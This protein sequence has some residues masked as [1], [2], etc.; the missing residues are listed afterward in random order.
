MKQTGFFISFLLAA[1]LVFINSAQAFQKNNSA[2]P[3][4]KIGLVLSGGGAKGMAHVG[5]IRA[6][7]KAGIRPDYV[8]GTSMGS[9]VG[10]LYAMGYN[11]EELEKIIRS[12]DWDLI[13]SNR[14]GFETIAFEEKEYYNRYLV[15]LPV[16][17]GKI[18]LPS[19][20]IEGQM[21]SEVLQYYTW[22]ARK[23]ANFDEFPI[24]F[25][26]IATDIGTGK[27]IVF[28]RG[29][30]HDALRSSIAIPTAF[31]AFQLDST[32]VVDGGVVNNF[33]VD[34]A[35]GLGA[36]IV[37]GVNVSDE[38]FIEAEKLEG[39]GAILMQLA[40]AQSLGKTSENI[41]LTD[42]YIK[43][44]LGPYGTASFGD[45]DAILKI[46]DKTGEIFYPRFKELA[47]S[48]GLNSVPNGIGLEAR[49]VRFSSIKVEGNRIFPTSLILS[50]LGI[51]QGQEVSREELQDGINRVFGINGFYKVDYKLVPTGSDEYELDIRVKEKSSHL[52]STSVHYDNQFSAGILLNYT[53]RDFIGK[54]SRTVLLADISQN[55]K[56]RFDYYKYIG[57]EKRFAFNLKANY[58]NQ[59]QP[60]YENG[61]TTGLQK[62]RNSKLEAQLIST[63]S[64]KQAFYLGMYF[65]NENSKYL[66]NDLA[67]EELKS[68]YQRFIGL[69]FRYYRNSQNDRNFPTHGAE[70]LIETNFN[71]KDWLGINTVAGADS[72]SIKL[73]EDFFRVSIEDFSDLVQLF[74]PNP[75]GTING[76]YSKY[77]SLSPKLQFHP[78]TAFGVIL[79]DESSSK[80]YREFFVGGYQNI[81]FGDTPFWGLN[82]AE[83]QT[84]NFLKVGAEFQLEPISKI[85]LRA[86]ANWLGYSQQYPIG[87]PD[88]TGKIFQDESYLGYGADV[89]Y[90][91]ILGPIS[92]GISSNSRDKQVRTYFSIGLSLNYSDR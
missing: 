76:R 66:L 50:K 35:K 33:P 21:L 10:G 73:G 29:Y 62:F 86:G 53:M 58:L 92:F 91:S 18:S 16:R 85:Y 52:L 88:W 3:K 4:P 40:M 49:P 54:F 25:R 68:A 81:R 89:S 64:L 23:Y 71:L 55:P 20:L 78:N 69:R 13:I 39:F 46:G 70:G 38:D 8:V 37:I 72:L 15:E 51:K 1:A 84:S 45:F 5:V 32:V 42:I 56:F 82:Y 90:N 80:I 28:D 43:P 17:N 67:S 65:E 14:V 11:S 41:A 19:G 44:E 22:P 87:D 47:D 34:V 27:A 31:T 2:N 7:E 24:P 12:I 6:M 30:L 36:D 74:R 59:G 60:T 77:F 83:V 48:L 61:K 57:K 9:V 75:Y 79:S 63:S 26:C